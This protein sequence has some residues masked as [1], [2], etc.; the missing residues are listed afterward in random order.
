MGS[1][2]AALPALLQLAVLV[3]A[4][5][6]ALAALN[7]YARPAR[8]AATAWDDGAALRCAVDDTPL[9]PDGS[10]TRIETSRAVS[11]G[12]VGLNHIMMREQISAASAMA[13]SAVVPAAARAPMA[14]MAATVATTASCCSLCSRFI[15]GAF[16]LDSRKC[17]R[18]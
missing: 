13:A 4:G 1:L 11:A 18:R 16:Q 17:S 15:V 6:G 9:V 2:D 8:D 7:A 14:V 3:L 5:I 10:R 12:R